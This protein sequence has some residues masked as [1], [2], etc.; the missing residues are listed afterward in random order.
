[1]EE[2]RT[3]RCKFMTAITADQNFNLAPKFDKMGNFQR[4]MLYFW[5]KNF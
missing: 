2:G 5:K 3:H 4:Q 1:M